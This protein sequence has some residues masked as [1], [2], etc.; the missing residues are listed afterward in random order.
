MR[1]FLALLM[2][3]SC[4][5]SFTCSA[6]V[7][8][9]SE[10]VLNVIYPGKQGAKDPRYQDLLEI[11]QTALEKTRAEFGPYQLQASPSNMNEGHYWLELYR[12]KDLNILWSSTSQEKEK[13]FLP[14][15]IPLR[16]GLL[17]YR[18]AL[19]KKN[20]QAAMRK[21]K[22]IE[23][24]QKLKIGQGWGWGD[25][26]VFQANGIATMPSN[27]E[28]LFTLL[29]SGKIDLFPR[30]I[31]EIEREMQ[32]YGPAN[33]K[34]AIEKE[35]LIHYPWPYYFFFNKNDAALKKRVETGLRMMLE[36]G[37]F[38]LIFWR[39]NSE[40]IKHANLSGRRLISLKN[41]ALPAETPL[42]ERELW[43]DPQ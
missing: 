16:K 41:P 27:Y 11:L 19:I 37:S 9:E 36:D 31:G 22:S 34:L 18:I 2:C 12:G 24:L 43:F 6:A 15:R 10:K 40:A 25:I 28:K 17:G 4:F 26:A 7:A 14:I 8:A 21:V 32:V 42:H 35:I 5:S 30:G 38:D 39:Y 23:D 20:Q 13:Y 33:T 3:F 29:E 1:I